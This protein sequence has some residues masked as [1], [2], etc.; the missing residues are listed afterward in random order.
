MK[1]H[2][3]NAITIYIDDMALTFMKPLSEEHEGK[4]LKVYEDAYGDMKSEYMT[5]NEIQIKFE[6]SGIE[7]R[8][9]LHNLTAFDNS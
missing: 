8:D 4:L 1:T 7:L 2:K 6:I 9:V 5:I 3:R